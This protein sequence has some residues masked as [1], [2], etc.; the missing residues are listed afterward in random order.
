MSQTDKQNS[1]KSSKSMKKQSLQ[2]NED[3]KQNNAAQIDEKMNNQHQKLNL[4]QETCQEINKLCVDDEKINNQCLV[5]IEEIKDECILNP[6]QHKY[7]YPCI[8]DWMKQKQ[9]CPLCNNEVVEIIK[10]NQNAEADNLITKVS[11]I[12]DSVALENLKSNSQSQNE[13]IERFECLDHNYL[14]NEVEKL[15]N[16]LDFVQKKMEQQANKY[17]DFN[18]FIIDTIDDQIYELEN[19]VEDFIEFNPQ[20]IAQRCFLLEEHLDIIRN[21]K[22]EIIEEHYSDL[23]A[24]QLQKEEEEIQ[25]YNQGN[26]KNKNNNNKNKNSQAN[27]KNGNSKNHIAEFEDDFYY[28]DSDVSS[29]P[30]SFKDYSIKNF[31]P[32][33]PKKKFNNTIPLNTASAMTKI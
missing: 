11:D 24:I 8:F 25:N 19:I 28:D 20:E 2:T 33:A 3:F 10:T 29:F 30:S 14:K 12:A 31:K 22:W 21:N 26:S 1:K 5:C 27:S 23:Y 15:L 7:C 16:K 17:D 6:C 4:K 9:R 13:H 32:K 18:W